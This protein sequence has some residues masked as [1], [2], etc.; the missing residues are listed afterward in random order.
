MNPV[1]LGA[2]A[3]GVVVLF[4]AFAKT[5]FD[6][7]PAQLLTQAQAD[8]QLGHFQAAWAKLDRLAR[9][10]EPTPMD[11][12]A[13]ALVARA[14]GT[15]A[16]AELAAIPDDHVLSSQAHLLAGQVEMDTG[17]VR[18]AEA[19]F[20]TAIERDASNI[21]ARR[22]LSYLYNIQHRFRELDTQMDALSAS[23]ALKFEHL[24]HWS[25][26]R[27]GRWNSAA[28]CERLA[29]YLAVDPA[30]RDT[31]LALAD[32]LQNLGRL[33]DAVLALAPLS[34]AD[35]EA[36]ARRAL[37]ALERGDGESAD[38]LLSGGSVDHPGLAKVRGLLALNR[39]N[40]GEAVRYLQIAYAA[41]PDDLAI[42]SALARALRLVGEH[43]RATELLAAERRHTDLTPLIA[44]ADSQMGPGDDKLPALLGAACEAAGRLAESRAWY[45]LA[46]VRNPLDS[47][48]QQALSRLTRISP[49]AQPP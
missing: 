29:K 9:V 17:R 45:R 1:R 8:Y 16:L 7:D 32:G 46:I 30:D 25:K 14:L 13:R 23:G 18:A 28:D 31:R 37:I 33:D 20:K 39:G 41:R 42:V 38:R 35:D 47:T 3:L 43:A 12:M 6:R 4:T 49:P 36:R 34:E 21:H 19:H 44:R 15:D 24:V 5:W 26:T 40:A 2:I 22:E 10:R 27:N 11:H 48:S